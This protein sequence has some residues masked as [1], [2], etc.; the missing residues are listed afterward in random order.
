[1]RNSIMIGILHPE[2]DFL[3]WYRDWS[4]WY[5]FLLFALGSL[6]VSFG[7]SFI[8]SMLLVSLW[9]W[10]IWSHSILYFIVVGSLRGRVSMCLLWC[11]RPLRLVTGLERSSFDHSVRYCIAGDVLMDIPQPLFFIF[12]FY[13]Q[14]SGCDCFIFFIS[15]DCDLFLIVMTA[16]ASE[17]NVLC[18]RTLYD[19]YGKNFT[20][21]SCE[22][23]SSD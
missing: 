17:K 9:M 13:F 1:M 2:E 22:I 15:S 11:W 5:V 23:Y 6:L 19:K 14:F 7:L 18:F 8:A 3:L 21:H 20:L 10:F 4:S 12:I 16:S